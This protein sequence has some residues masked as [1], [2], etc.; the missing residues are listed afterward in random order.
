MTCAKIRTNVPYSI[1][2]GMLDFL[3]NLKQKKD[4]NILIFVCFIVNFF[5]SK[6]SRFSLQ[7]LKNDEVTF[8]YHRSVP[9]FIDKVSIL[10]TDN[11]SK[12]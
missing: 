3:Y 12:D 10:N 8:Y 5:I 7:T 4:C 2:V 11:D 9:K 1:N 6:T